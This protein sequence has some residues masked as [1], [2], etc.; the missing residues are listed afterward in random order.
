MKYKSVGIAA[1]G[2]FVGALCAE[3][4]NTLE[5]RAA[6]SGFKISTSAGKKLESTV[7]EVSG[8]TMAAS[9]KGLRSGHSGTSHSPGVVYNLTAST[10]S[11]SEVLFQWTSVGAEGFSG[12]AAYVEV[13][14]ATYPITYANY[15]TINSSFTVVALTPGSVE[16]ELYGGL[17]AGKTY[18]TA[19]RVR[20]GSN[21]YGRLSANATFGTAPVRPRAPVVSGVVAAGSF[22]ISWDAVTS[23]VAGSTITVQNYEVYYST[24]LNGVVNGPI[25]L[26]SS[27]LA[28]SVAT[29]PSY[30]YFVKALD[31]EGFRSDSSVW[32]NNADEVTRTVADDLRAVVDMSPYVED[33][34]A[35]SGLVPVL[36]HKPEY[37]AG[38]TVVSY[39]FYFRDA[40]NAEVTQHL[41][42]DVTL[43][44]P[45]SRTA[46][47]NVSAVSPAVSYSAY[48]YSAYYYN[49]VEDVKIGGTVN[50]ADGSVSILTRVTGLYKVKQVIRAQSF[51]IIQTQP[52]KIFTPNGDG[53]WDTFNIVYDNPEGLAITSAK[54][55]DLSGAEIANLT[56]GSFGSSASLAWDGRRSNGDKAVSGIYIYQFK[57]GSKF[58]NGTMVVAR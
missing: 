1:V 17:S 21:M 23:N 22:T 20:D 15:S 7:G 6:T 46:A 34:L 29:T 44:L 35:S 30:W 4:A 13:K 50:P 53:V 11:A 25:T 36:E 56:S 47:F 43:I 33:F 26:S 12:Q 39:K 37:E 42:E 32:L 51:S 2:L 55:Y 31:S 3:A 54:V 27:T 16:Q 19:V 28:H 9:G 38:S 18:Y 40:A 58:Y 45:L 5:T 8:S 41:A 48:D 14:I 52:R 24:A 49:G 57:A 10:T